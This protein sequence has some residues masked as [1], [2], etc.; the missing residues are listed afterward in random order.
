MTFEGILE[1]LVSDVLFLVIAIVG[2]WLLYK[3]TYRS[4][5]L[6]FFGIHKSR[7]ITV[8]LSNLRGRK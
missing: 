7:R 6:K 1:N 2:G 3:I 4:R 8:Y 5:L